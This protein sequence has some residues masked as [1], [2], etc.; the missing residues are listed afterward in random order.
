M[1][2]SR[3][4]MYINMYNYLYCE[5]GLQMEHKSQE[6]LHHVGTQKMQNYA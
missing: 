3:N 5:N 6:I 4:Y 1:A 2:T